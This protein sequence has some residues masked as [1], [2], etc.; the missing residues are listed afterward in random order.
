MLPSKESS[1]NWGM[2]GY[3]GT[4]VD[5]AIKQDSLDDL[6][7]CV[8]RGYID[9]TTDVMGARSI[10]DLCVKKKAAKCEKWLRSEGWDD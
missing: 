4:V 2:F 5:N 6:K 9:K 3:E 8:K 1:K 10:V 7:E